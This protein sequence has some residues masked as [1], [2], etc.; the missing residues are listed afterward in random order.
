MLAFSHVVAN[1]VH[2][3]VLKASL[4]VFHELCIVDQAITVGVSLGKV[5][6]SSE[7]LFRTDHLLDAVVLA[8]LLEL[9]L[10]DI[11]IFVGVCTLEDQVDALSESFK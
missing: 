7:T 4:A 10:V 5:R 11:A 2:E 3:L 8:H 1:F 6:E 9:S